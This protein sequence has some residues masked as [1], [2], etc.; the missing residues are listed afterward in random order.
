MAD[1]HA[2]TGTR[3]TFACAFE[4]R[5]TAL[6]GRLGA[7]HIVDVPFAFDTITA[8]LQTDTS[9]LSAAPAARALVQA[10]HAAWCEFIA[11]G[12]PGWKPHDVSE[13]ATMM[14][15]QGLTVAA[16]LFAAQ[17]AAWTRSPG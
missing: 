17:R 13:R 3:S 8:G 9:P 10:V 12:S 5:S 1:G 2:A 7:D 4:W 15:G 6:A 16:D 14:L 11:T